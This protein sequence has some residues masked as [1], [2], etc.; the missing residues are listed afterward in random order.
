MAEDTVY[1]IK[2]NK[3]LVPL[4]GSGGGANIEVGTYSGNGR[5]TR[6]INVEGTI[7]FGIVYTVGEPLAMTITSSGDAYAYA[8]M[9]TPSG[10]SKA[11]SI[12]SGG[13]Q[14]QQNTTSPMD[15]KRAVLNQSGKTYVYV[16]FKE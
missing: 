2:E 10:S 1:G 5:T 15:G 13:F 11:V 4:G 3:A 12:V 16:L 7:K 9:M 14:V 6:V 8:A